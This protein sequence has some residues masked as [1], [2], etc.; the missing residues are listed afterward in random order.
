MENI[1]AV[2][3]LLSVLPEVQ[4]IEFISTGGFKAVFRIEFRDGRHEALKV[5]LLPEDDEEG[6]RDQFL[7][8]VLREIAVLKNCRSPYLVKLG[9]WEPKL[10]QI[11]GWD[12]LLYTEEFLDGA[13]VIDLIEKAKPPLL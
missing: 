6:L 10:V 1:P 12:Y 3:D 2:E 9:S 5:L 8:R 11:A 7:A 13:P 4:S